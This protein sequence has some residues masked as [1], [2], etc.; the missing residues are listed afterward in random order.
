MS[1]SLLP[2]FGSLVT[3]SEYSNLFLN[4]VAVGTY[5]P[6]F[7]TLG[8][9]LSEQVGSSLFSM[10]L[11]TFQK[12]YKQLCLFQ[13]SFLLKTPMVVSICCPKL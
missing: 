3:E 1:W 12:V 9:C 4:S 13:I 5:L 10:F 8:E 6:S 7:L 11:R 2:G